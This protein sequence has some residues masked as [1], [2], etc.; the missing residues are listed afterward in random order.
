MNQPQSKHSLGDDFSIKKESIF[1]AC[2]LWLK[3]SKNR[4]KLSSSLSFEHQDNAKMKKIFFSLM[5][6]IHQLPYDQYGPLIQSIEDSLHN[7][8]RIYEIVCIDELKH[9]I[10]TS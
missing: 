4:G 3:P 5:K 9:V 7:N 6:E 8:H 1:N 10:S 2:K